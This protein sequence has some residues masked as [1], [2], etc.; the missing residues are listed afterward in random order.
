M[1]KLAIPVIAAIG[2]AF[3]TG[4]LASE[5]SGT[6]ETI[7]QAHDSITLSDG[8]V[9]RLPENIEVEDLKQGE[10][11]SVTYDADDSGGRDISKIRR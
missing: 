7:D 1:K 5:A 4:A 2:V 9:Y 3:A 10:K 11:V 8:K 6:I